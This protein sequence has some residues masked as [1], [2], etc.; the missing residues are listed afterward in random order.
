[1]ASP[2]SPAGMVGR[3]CFSFLFFFPH[4]FI[5]VLLTYN[6]LHILKVYSLTSCNMYAPVKPS[7]RLTQPS[8]CK[9]PRHFLSNIAERHT[10]GL[11]SP[12]SI[13]YYL[14][15]LERLVTLSMLVLDLL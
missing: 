8:P 15:D 14:G 12:D 4:S 2:W 3:K 5:E 10:G 11:R 1:M 9:F 6:N 7:L 13:L